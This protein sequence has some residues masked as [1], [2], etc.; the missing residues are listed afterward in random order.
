MKKV[1]PT[2]FL[3]ELENKNVRIILKWDIAFE[4]ILSCTDK[5]MNIVIKNAVRIT[6]SGE[7]DIGDTCIRCNNIKI[8]EE[9]I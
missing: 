6:E 3:K 8:I 9:I 1:T 7:L 4:G 2:V 5:Y